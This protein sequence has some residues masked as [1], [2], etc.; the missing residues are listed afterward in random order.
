[1]ERVPEDAAADVEGG[2]LTPTQRQRTPDGTPRSVNN[3]VND[4]HRPLLDQGD[5]TMSVISTR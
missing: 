5:D 2:D 3:N 1:M 4:L